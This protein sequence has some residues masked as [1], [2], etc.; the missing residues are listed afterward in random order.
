MNTKMS[1]KLLMIKTAVLDNLHADD[2]INFRD[3]K[4]LATESL[5]KFTNV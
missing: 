3:I 4:L 1:E 2:P 5:I